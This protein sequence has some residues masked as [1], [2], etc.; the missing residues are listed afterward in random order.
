MIYISAFRE[1]KRYSKKNDNKILLEPDT[2]DNKQK[3]V[4]S[5]TYRSKE[6]DRI[7]SS[8]NNLNDVPRKKKKE[9]VKVED[10]EEVKVEDEEKVK[11]DEKVTKNK[12][13]QKKN[14]FFNRFVPAF[15]KRKSNKTRKSEDVIFNDLNESL[16]QKKNTDQE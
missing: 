2:D 16:L 11:V 15:L 8:L 3:L 13:K 9:E 1:K 5:L 4:K 10:E 12:K 14:W 6:H 7:L